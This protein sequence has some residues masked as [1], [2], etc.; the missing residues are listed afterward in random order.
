MRHARD[1]LGLLFLLIGSSGLFAADLRV[2][3]QSDPLTMDPHSVIS[4]AAIRVRWQV[5]EALT[6]RDAQ[7]RPAPSLATSWTHDGNRKWV[8]HLRQKVLFHD[9]RAFTSDDVLFSLNRALSATSELRG[10]VGGIEHIR[11]LDKFTVEIVTKDRDPVLD[12]KLV[13][14]RIMSKSWAIEK[15]AELPNDYRNKRQSY[16]SNHANGTGPYRLISYEQDSSTRLSANPLWW[17]GKPHYEAATLHVITSGA[18]RT[19]A[20][21]S[22]E[23]DVVV[24]PA[25]SDIEALRRATSKFAIDTTPGFGTVFLGFNQ[26]PDSK[27][28]DPQLRR[29]ISLAIDRNLLVSK[30]LGGTA[31]PTQSWLPEGVEGH[32]SQFDS[33]AAASPEKSRDL[34]TKIGLAD[35]LTADLYCST[36]HPLPSVAAGLASMLA[37]IG[38]SVRIITLPQSEFLRRL[39]AGLPAMFLFGWNSPPYASG[40]LAP[41]LASSPTDQIHAAN[42][43]QI[44]DETVDKLLAQIQRGQSKAERDSAT[45]QLQVHLREAVPYVPL[46]R[47]NITWASRSTIQLPPPDKQDV[48]ELVKAR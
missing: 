37:K 47:R 31:T 42:Y 21:I 45:R 19:A 6:A 34:L 30:L 15:N 12:Q 16:I 1:Y 33:F 44:R 5:Y 46:Y 38:I 11:A 28:K 13:Y 10:V 35:G 40:T 7:Y 26:S 41:L 20:L 8:F 32:D 25:Q 4:T 9:G 29:A 48:L 22:G 24:D 14:V 17:G 43:G 2:A 18:A 27:F 3:S 36:V 23:I 39:N